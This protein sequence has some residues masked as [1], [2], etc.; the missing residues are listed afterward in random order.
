MA[1]LDAGYQALLADIFQRFPSVQ[2][3]GFNDAYKP[4]LAAMEAFDAALGHPSRAFRSIHVA[5]TNGKGTVCNLLASAL[6]A[7][8]MK[9]GLYTSPHIH[10]FRER[11]R[12]ATPG[13]EGRAAL[14]PKSYVFDFLTEW[15]PYFEAQGLSFFEITTGLAFRWFADEGVELAVIETGLGG[16]LDSTNI[17]TPDLAI[18][19]TVDYDHCALLGDT[20]AAIAGEKAGIF[21][22]AVPALVGQS[23][24]ETDPVFT[25]VARDRCPLYFADRMTPSLWS[26]RQEVLTAMDLHGPCRE[27]N[28]RTVLAAV[29]LLR[30][31]PAYAALRRDDALLAGVAQTARRMGFHGRWERLSEEP[32]VFCDIGHN[33]QALR[34][35]FAQLE[36]LRADEGFD[37]LLLVY[38]V[39]A[40]KDTDAILP[41]LPADAR[42]FF[43]APATPR[44]LPVGELLARFTA[45]RGPS[46]HACACASVR[47]AVARALDAAR[48]FTRPLVFIGGSTFV[49]SEARPAF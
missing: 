10:D 22:T 35:T 2:T 20:L 8:G 9:T 49:V 5:G 15:K 1:D 41:L 7:A 28:L 21:K 30:E 12:I 14:I 37:A 29:D 38:G 45:L 40:D 4:G 13:P 25:E 11:A 27:Q 23:R 17:L 16:R 33:P 3:V 34:A 44:A 47:E 32:C 26:R 36:R 19:T 24:A 18:V 43:A 48:H 46:P 31:Q 39:M 6:S 42:Y